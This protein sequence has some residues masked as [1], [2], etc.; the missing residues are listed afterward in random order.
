MTDPPE[1]SVPA[2]L[3]G[4]PN[5]DV[6]DGDRIRTIT[7]NRPEAKGAMRGDMWSALDAA[8]SDSQEHP[9]IAVVVLTGTA[10]AFCA[11][12]D[13]NEMAEIAM[14]TGDADAHAFPRMADTMAAFTKPLLVAVNGIG[15][16]FGATVLGLADLAFMSSTARIKCPFTRLGVAPELAS[17][18]TFPTLIGRQNATWALLS[19]EWLGA[20]ECERM[21]LVFRVCEPDELLDV[22]MEHA[23]VLAAK[24]ISSLVESKAAILAAMAPQIAAA[25]QREDEAFQRLLG[26]PEN[27]EAMSAFAE[28]REPDFSK[29]A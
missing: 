1:S 24:P 9:G 13:L 8:L 5:I 12:V 4:C 2:D 17:S 10:D 3:N 21:G 22:T 27:L 6:V 25:R 29:P 15:V 20:E 14:G 23:R 26:T 18:Y 19:S 16:G 28:K 11:G 7:I